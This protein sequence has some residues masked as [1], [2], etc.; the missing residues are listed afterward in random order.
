MRTDFYEVALSGGELTEETAHEL[1]LLYPYMAYWYAGFYVVIEGWRDLGPSDPEIDALLTSL[2]VGFLRRF[3]NGAF[4]Y[5][6][7]Y[8]HEKLLGFPHQADAPMWIRDVREGL[9]RWFLAF[10]E[11]D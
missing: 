7:A 10:L 3:R 5:Q 1:F 2:N 6:R 4:H 11:K 9:S 8:A